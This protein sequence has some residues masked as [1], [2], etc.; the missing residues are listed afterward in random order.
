MNNFSNYQKKHT[1]G[2]IL[3]VALFIIT[4]LQIIIVGLVLNHRISIRENSDFLGVNQAINI[5]LG[6]EDWARSQIYN[7]YI[8]NNNLV[9]SILPRTNIQG[10]FLEGYVYDAQGKFNLN[11]LENGQVDGFNN[12]ISNLISNQNGLNTDLLSTLLKDQFSSPILTQNNIFPYISV[13]ELRAMP[14]INQKIYP[15][16]ADNVTV[17]P[18]IT[19]LN[20]NSATAGGLMSLGPAVTLQTANALIKIRDNI[21]GFTTTGAFS[22]L[23][24]ENM[25]KNS[26]QGGNPNIAANIT[27]QSNYFFSTFTVHYQNIDLT[28]NSLLKIYEDEGRIKVMV[29]WRSFGPL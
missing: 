21:G 18:D 3:I 10:G 11:N 22:A 1:Q 6:G 25:A 26:T 4:L 19:P 17:L 24:A 28:L 29:L 27:I 13:T 2:T 12:M 14:G 23:L 5:A 9:S 7:S 8:N 15:I 20:I 16:L